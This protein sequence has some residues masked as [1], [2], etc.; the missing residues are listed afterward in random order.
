MSSWILLSRK[1]KNGIASLEIA[2]DNK[3]YAAVSFREKTFTSPY[4]VRLALQESLRTGK[5]VPLVVY[6]ANIE[7]IVALVNGTIVT[8]GDRT[9][10]IEPV[11]N[12]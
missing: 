12:A 2:L 11:P 3:V 10:F 6:P 8:F 5:A 1:F 7:H 4:Y 9:I